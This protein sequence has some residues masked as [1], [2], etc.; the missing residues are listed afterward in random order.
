M[1]ECSKCKK[2]GD[3]LKA[4]AKC[5][6]TIYCS[7]DC[8]K[9][10]WKVHKKVCAKNAQESWGSGRRATGFTRPGAGSGARGL[11]TTITNPMTRLHQ[12][13]W[14]HDR[15]EKDVYK[16][17]IDSYRLKMAD[18]FNL[19]GKPEDD[20]IYTPAGAANPP[21]GF[22]KYLTQAASKP[23][24]LPP[25]WNEEK[26]KEC[27]ALAM[28]GDDWLAL[29][30]KVQK[31][32]INGHYGDDRFAMQLRLVREQI[33]GR[34]PA[35]QPGA[36]MIKQMMQFEGGAMGPDAVSSIIDMTR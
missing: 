5:R 9:D 28:A 35:G 34:G 18:D 31:G 22:Q 27:E 6:T 14:L 19:E 10:D 2:T 30:K 1:A 15:T 20:S 17:L 29:N 33:T 32:D 3:H 21:A 36:A 11:E 16:L 12:K 13:T 25:W 24:L 23:G 8:Q 4:C 7:R 26:Q